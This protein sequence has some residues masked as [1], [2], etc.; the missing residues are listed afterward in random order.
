LDIGLVLPLDIKM[1]NRVENDLRRNYVPEGILSLVVIVSI[2]LSTY[3]HDVISLSQQL[4]TI[5][6]GVC[7][8]ANTTISPS[9]LLA[10][11]ASSYEV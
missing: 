9:S 5:P 2:T 7:P 4:G 1:A 10:A 3:Q 8:I 11:P 6:R